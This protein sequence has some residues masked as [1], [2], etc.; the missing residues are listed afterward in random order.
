MTESRT[1]LTKEQLIDS[2]ESL[3]RQEQAKYES[4]GN[5]Q[6]LG[7]MDAL[8]KAITLAEQT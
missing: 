6:A 3:Y 7:A 1:V 5:L 4:T 2:L 8:D